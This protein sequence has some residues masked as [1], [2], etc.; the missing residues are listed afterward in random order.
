MHSTLHA[1]P[2]LQDN[3]IWIWVRGKNA[4]VVD[5]AVA[6]PVSQW[7]NSHGIGLTAILQTHHHADHIGGTPELLRE[8]PQA[9][10]VAAAADR[11]R[12]PF[13]TMGVSDGDAINVLGRRVEVMDVAAHT[14]A[15]IA[16]ILRDDAEKDPNLG[17]LVFCGDTL[18]AGGC[19]RLFEGSA[20]DMYRALQ[21]LAAL[22]DET[23]V[24]CAHE[25]TEANLRWA[26]EQRP[27][28]VEI[29]SRYQ[30]VKERRCRG[31]LSLPSSIG[32]EKR[33]NL[34]MQAESIEQLAELRSHKD[35]W[36]SN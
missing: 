25:Y 12:I 16:F 21:R 19:G 20:Q 17:P 29:T 11:L 34:F 9:E 35:H 22:P 7:L 36:R 18:F 33:T 5:P 10:V 31:D 23:L 6:K 26:T 4:V 3:V 32:A 28:D 1:L 27:N 30:S 13:Q 8:W 15:H 14:S 24:C 2:V